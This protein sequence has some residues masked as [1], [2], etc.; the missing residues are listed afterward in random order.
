MLQVQRT[1]YLQSVAQLITNAR[2]KK[3]AIM[4]LYR[5]IFDTRGASRW[6]F[7][8]SA[9]FERLARS[10]RIFFTEIAKKSRIGNVVT[11]VK[12]A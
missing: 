4:S 6:E 11:Y 3:R 12:I 9:E 1:F 7:M 8:S 10:S 2:F 5:E